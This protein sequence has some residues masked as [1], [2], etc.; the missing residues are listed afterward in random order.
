MGRDR[1]LCRAATAVAVDGSRSDPGWR[2]HICGAA[3]PHVAAQTPHCETLSKGGAHRTS[4]R[5]MRGRGSSDCRRNASEAAA[6]LVHR[7]DSQL[8]AAR[9]WQAEQ[10]AALQDRLKKEQDELKAKLQQILIS[11]D[12]E[13]TRESMRVANEMRS[14]ADA[15]AHT[16]TD[17]LSSTD[18]QIQQQR[19]ELA[20]ARYSQLQH[21]ANRLQAGV[22]QGLERIST[23]RDEVR[24]RFPDW[25]MVLKQEPS[26]DTTLDY[27][28]IGW[29]QVRE[30]LTNLLRPNESK[31]IA[32]TTA[33]TSSG[34]NGSAAIEEIPELLAAAEIPAEI[35]VVLHRRLHSGLIIQ[36]S[37]PH[38]DRA[39]DL[40]HQVLWRLLT[41]RPPRAQTDLDRSTWKG[42]AFHELH[43]AGRSRSIACGTSCLDHRC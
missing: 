13:Y 16:I 28:P 18:Q 34:G 24:E 41:G 32:T 31:P 10:L 21:L 1:L 30:S 12:E 20:S 11:T 35:P 42:T 29:L 4:R 3:D 43:G 37:A 27:I 33:E 22:S 5:S 15:L 26:G 7:R 38:L 14:K 9:K 39:I 40:A 23:T 36:A 17:E 19:D 8:E 25:N 6:E 2:A